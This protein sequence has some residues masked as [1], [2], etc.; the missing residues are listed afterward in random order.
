ML[1]IH[2]LTTNKLNTFSST[3]RLSYWVHKPILHKNSLPWKKNTIILNSVLQASLCF[4]TV[5]LIYPNGTARS[6]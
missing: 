3:T 4:G 6:V 2:T 1:N 5:T